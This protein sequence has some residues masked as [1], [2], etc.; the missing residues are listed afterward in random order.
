MDNALACHSGGQGLIPPLV[1]SEEAVQ[2]QNGFFRSG[3]RYKNAARR[4]KYTVKRFQVGNK[5]TYPS[6]A[7][8]GRLAEVE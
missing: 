2:K 6:H 1:K 4:G 5:M 8:Y 7:I 3:G